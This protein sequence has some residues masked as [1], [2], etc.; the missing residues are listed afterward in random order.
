MSEGLNFIFLPINGSLSIALQITIKIPSRLYI[1]K[2]CKQEGK[3]NMKYLNTVIL[4]F[5]FFFSEQ[6]QTELKLLKTKPE[7]TKPKSPKTSRNFAKKMYL[8]TVFFQL[9]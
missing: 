2:I 3:G 8:V 6:Q 7:T 9:P 1:N 5:S 4:I